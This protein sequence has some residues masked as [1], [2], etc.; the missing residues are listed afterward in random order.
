MAVAALHHN[1]LGP[2][3]LTHPARVAQTALVAGLD[4]FLLDDLR[5]DE[6]PDLLVVAFD[7]ADPQRHADL[8]GRQ[9]GA[10]SIEHGL[11]QI[12][13]EALDGRVDARDFLRFLAKDWIFKGE[14]WPNHELDSTR[15]VRKPN[16]GRVR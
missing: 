9:P 12:I 11:G 8:V 13:Q 15:E 3:H 1:D 7:D 4:A 5:I 14:N 10:R 16:L 6:A 2:L